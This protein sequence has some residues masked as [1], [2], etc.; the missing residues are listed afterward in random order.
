MLIAIRLIV[1]TKQK[2][3]E[4]D[5]DNQGRLG[6]SGL[7][8][9]SEWILKS[10]RR[11]GV[12]TTQDGIEEMKQ[13]ILNVYGVGNNGYITISELASLFEDINEVP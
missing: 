3:K 12:P 7:L 8:K 4:F 13:R 1:R 6:E 9:L 11:S 10:Y 2:F 5:T